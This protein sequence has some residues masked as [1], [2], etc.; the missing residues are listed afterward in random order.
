MFGGNE[1]LTTK[2]G[3]CAV[4]YILSA[5]GDIRPYHFGL[6]AY[7]NASKEDAKKDDISAIITDGEPPSITLGFSQ[8]K[9]CWA[10]LT[11]ADLALSDHPKQAST[12]P[13]PPRPASTPR[14][15]INASSTQPTRGQMVTTSTTGAK[16]AKTGSEKTPGESQESNANQLLSTETP[17]STVFSL[18]AGALIGLGALMGWFL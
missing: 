12:I 2:N 10:T 13:A 7:G 1:V 9:A 8:L 5:A 15:G 14:W 3:S 11:P 16:T 18:M 17:A 4:P 6:M